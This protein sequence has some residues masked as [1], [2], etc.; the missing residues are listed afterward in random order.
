MKDRINFL[1]H[2]LILFVPIFSFTITY[3]QTTKLDLD[4]GVLIIAV[5]VYETTKKKDVNQDGGEK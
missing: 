2:T 4:M 1:A 5:L 3:I